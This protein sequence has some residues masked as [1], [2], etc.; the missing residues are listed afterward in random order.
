MVR[1]SAGSKSR[2][3]KVAGAEP[4]GQRR[5]EKLHAAVARST[6]ATQN[7]KRTDGLGPLFE[8]Q[9]S[10]SGTPLWCVAHL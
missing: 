5:H 7:I 8:V 6:F 10:K 1:G 4:C 2:L 3:A 9:L